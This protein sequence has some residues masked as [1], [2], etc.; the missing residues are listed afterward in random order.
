M[1]IG[2]RIAIHCKMPLP[3]YPAF[4]I[5]SPLC[6]WIFMLW[7][8]W[9]QNVWRSPGGNVGNTY[10]LSVA[11][12]GEK[13]QWH[14]TYCV[15]KVN[16]CTG[17]VLARSVL[18]LFASPGNTGPQERREAGWELELIEQCVCVCRSWAEGQG[19]GGLI[20]GGKRVNLTYGYGYVT[21]QPWWNVR[22]V[23]QWH[24]HLSFFW[25]KEKELLLY[26]HW[27]NPYKLRLQLG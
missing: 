15:G 8:R 2:T 10:H 24:F 6:C 23:V 17:T 5:P 7:C 20:Q 27:A 1:N 26:S 13:P 4:C 22:Q 25:D 14:T 12:A 18:E 9:R 11:L 16:S 19:T 3:W 21:C